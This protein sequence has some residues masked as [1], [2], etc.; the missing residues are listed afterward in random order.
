MSDITE[1]KAYNDLGLGK[2]DISVSWNTDGVQ[3]FKSSKYAVWPLQL[4]INE[5]PFKER[6][7][8]ILLAG[9]W[10]GNEKPIVDCF[11]QPFVEE[12]NRLSTVGLTWVDE[13]TTKHTRVFPGPC[14]LDTVARGMVMNM[15]QFNGER[16]C[17]WCEQT[18]EVVPKGK[19][20]VR[21]YPV[22]PL[23]GK[24]RSDNSF[25][26]HARQAD[27]SG[28][29]VAGVKGSTILFMLAFFKFPF[30][31]VVDYMHAVCS[32]FV[33]HTACMWLKHKKTFPYSIGALIP[34]ID[35]RLMSLRPVCEMTRLPRSLVLRKYWKSSEWRNWLLYFSPVVLHG[36]LP[37]VYYN[38]WLE[39]VHL[40]HFLLG[41]VVA[42]DQLKSAQKEMIKFLGDYEKLYGK[43]HLT[44]NAHALLHLVDC[45]REWGPLWNY[46]A[47]PYEDMNGQLGRFV[48]GTRHAHLQ[49]VQKF[50]ILSIMPVLCS[51]S[52]ISSSVKQLVT[53]MLR[54]H[55]LRV[56]STCLF[57]YTFLGKGHKSERGTEYSK[58]IANG[59]TLCVRTLDKSRRANSYVQVTSSPRV[60]GQIVSVV[61]AA[62]EWHTVPCSCTPKV[63][64]VL[65]K[66]N[67]KQRVLGSTDS[68][69]NDIFFVEQSTQILKVDVNEIRKCVALKVQNKLFVGP[70]Q[71]TY[72]IEVV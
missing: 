49:I 65:K 38:N 70:L 1:S 50:S 20:H 36:I 5:L 15:H 64:L 29:P 37:Q 28:E 8:K 46:S 47:Y 22:E 16:G 60:F 72:A 63:F 56:H 41:D 35:E 39:F 71:R 40:M 54:G 68:S 44:F 66:L 17:A 23:K 6:V 67:I 25:R 2:D 18:G 19:G 58:V 30:G 4:Q 31:F 11:L 3:L 59:Y 48:N 14:V 32:G 10:F 69:V 62:C 34:E 27:Q 52:T 26:C 55:K 21:V 9:L 57:N 42:S 12:M 45:V 61:H 24:M 33:R 53:T 43:K 13:G 51:Q 7:K